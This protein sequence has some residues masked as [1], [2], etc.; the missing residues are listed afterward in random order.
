MVGDRKIKQMNKTRLNKTRPI[1]LKFVLAFWVVDHWQ[2]TIRYN[3][4]ICFYSKTDMSGEKIGI[5]KIKKL[6]VINGKN[7]CFKNP[8]IV[9]KTV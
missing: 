3:F 6:N 1:S 5:K 4:Q 7:H 9:I 2:E 8:E